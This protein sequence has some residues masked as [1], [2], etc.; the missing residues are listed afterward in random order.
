MFAAF[1]AMPADTAIPA[2]LAAAVAPSEKTAPIPQA[3]PNPP[4]ATP[5]A[6]TPPEAAASSLSELFLEGDIRSS[7]V[8]S[9]PFSA[10]N[11]SIPSSCD[12][13]AS[14]L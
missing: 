8:K 4:A 9:I 5:H 6:F 3:I 10:A 2:E 12:A 13:M 7:M 1:E 11:F 14:W